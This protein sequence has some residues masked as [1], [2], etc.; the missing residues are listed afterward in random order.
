[1][2]PNE[3]IFPSEA[4]VISKQ[5]MITFQGIPLLVDVSD[6]QNVQVVRILSSNPQHF[7]DERIC[8]GAKISVNQEG[9][10]AL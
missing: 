3:L 4:D 1:M 7:M 8:P 6:Q 10:S 2:M 5:Q 9:L